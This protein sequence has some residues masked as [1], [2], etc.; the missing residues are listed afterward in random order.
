MN[1]WHFFNSIF[2]GHLNLR[3]ESTIKNRQCY[4]FDGVNGLRWAVHLHKTYKLFRRITFIYRQYA[5][6]TL[7]VFIYKN[8]KIMNITHVNCTQL[9]HNLVAFLFH[10]PFIFIYYFLFFVG[11]R[12]KRRIVFDTKDLHISCISFLLSFYTHR[13]NCRSCVW[14]VTAR[15]KM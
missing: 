2:Y 3:N 10:L 12:M 6:H 4:L 15:K 5:Q 14:I 13:H 11:H 8:S 1:L 9:S 7:F